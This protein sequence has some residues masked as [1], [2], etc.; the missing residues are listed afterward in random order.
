MAQL[1]G[2]Q[3]NWIARALLLSLPV[4]FISGLIVAGAIDRSDYM[5]DR[6]SLVEQPIP[7]S[8]KHHVGQLGLDCRYCHTQVEQS[9]AALLPSS[10]ICLT[11]HVQIWKDAPLLQPIRKAEPIHWQKVTK[12]PEF[13]Y[14]N[15][16]IHVQKGIGCV[17]C[18]GDVS[19][20]SLTRLIHPMTMEFCLNCHRAPERFVR[21][22][23]QVFSAAAAPLSRADQE[24]LGS[25]L[26]ERYGIQKK[27]SCVTCHR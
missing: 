26:V 27:V 1:F 8:H 24:K 9:A 13:V 10:E 20:M 23:E 15:H 5:T 19:S 12:L 2:P 21:P 6:N 16:S 7:F 3:S 17:S 14:F 4:L 22:Q 25:E 18:H 11:C